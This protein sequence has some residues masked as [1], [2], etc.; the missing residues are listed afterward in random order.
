MK[1]KHLFG[2]VPSRRLGISLG[3]DLVPHKV[4]SM[5]CIYCEV[6]KTTNL[7]NQRGDYIP[8]TELMSELKQYLKDEPELDYITF[9][10][11]GE[12]L[13]HEG[14]G[15]IIS[16][17]KNEYTQYKLALITNSTQLV[18][19]QVR[20]DIKQIDLILPSLDSADQAVFQKINRGSAD[21]NVDKIIAGLKAFKQESNCE[22]W[23][24]VFFVPSL[25]DN[26]ADLEKLKTAIT[27]IAPDQV[28]LNTLDRPGTEPGLEPLTEERMDE[29][30]DFLKPLPVEIIAK[31]KARNKISS[32]Q[33]DIE[34]AI[35]ETIKRRP[36]T[37]IDLAEMLGTHINEI[38]KYI[39]SLLQED[40]IISEEQ[41]RGTFF[42][43][44]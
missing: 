9:S 41:E 17:I 28:Q 34:S 30:A 11:A 10:G 2:P 33:K 31:F 27:E 43:A 24:E 22:M 8:L 19:P 44:R 29:I 1:F 37:A 42:R 35:L 13:L 12:P 18:D 16:F 6:G 3:V 15:E 20:N 25:N 32:F 14:I 5:N 21:L 4:C 23:L 40:K 26:E 39:G 38:N 36:C 7:T